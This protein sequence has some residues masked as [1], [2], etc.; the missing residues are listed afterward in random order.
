M[1][2]KKIYLWTVYR[3]LEGATLTLVALSRILPPYLF[4]GLSAPPLRAVIHVLVPRRRV[5]R[6]LQAAFGAAYSPSTIKGL[7]KGVQDH[8]T[9]NLLDCFRHMAEPDRTL[10]TII[11]EGMDNLQDALAKGKGVIALGAHIGNFVLVG[12][13]LGMVGYK[14]HTLFRVP[15]EKRLRDFI[16]RHL[17]SFHQRVI[18]SRPRR[19]AVKRIL[20]ALKRNEIVFILGDNLKKGE[21]ETILFGQKVPSPRGPISLALRSGAPVVPMHLIRNYDGGLRLIIEREIVMSRNG[22]MSHDI[23]ENTRQIVRY[24]E[25]LI[26][27]YP[28]QWNWLTVK[29]RK[30]QVGGR[31]PLSQA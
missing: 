17:P 2:F 19:L 23:T 10:E 3:L 7:A 12:A 4:E 6:N 9:K 13:R 24:L 18:P 22:S 29:M 30:R 14:F 11:V 21:I 28:D 16:D 20:E 5:R 15:P 1:N 25:E 31:A 27:R 8:F 26:R